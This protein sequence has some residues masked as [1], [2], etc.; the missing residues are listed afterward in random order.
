MEPN[1]VDLLESATAALNNSDAEP[2]L[3]LTS[4]NMVW[5]GFPRGW[6]WWRHTPH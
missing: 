5:T 6:L 3:D 4:D 1:S 2:L